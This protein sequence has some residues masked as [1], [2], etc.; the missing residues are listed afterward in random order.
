MLKSRHSDNNSTHCLLLEK[1][2]PKQQLNI[3]GSI[4]DAN[5]KI[6]G[7]FSL[8]N[9]FGFEFSPRD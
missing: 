2:T 4:V 3:K 5:N 1:L 7:V 8:F 6:N 9:P